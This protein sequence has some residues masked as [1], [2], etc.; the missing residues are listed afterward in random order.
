MERMFATLALGCVLASAG[1]AAAQAPWLGTDRSPRLAAEAFKPQFDN[2]KYVKGGSSALFLSGRIRATDAVSVIAEAP[3]AFGGYRTDSDASAQVGNPYLGVELGPS[4]SPVWVEIGG[5]VPLVGRDPNSGV[6]VGML[7]DIDRFSAFL[8]QTAAL[9]GAVD[10]GVRD[11]SGLGFRARFGPELLVNT[12]SN[13]EGDDTETFLDYG[14][15][16]FWVQGPLDLRL[17]VAGLYNA[18]AEGGDFGERSMHQLG[19]AASY[20][21]AG[22]RPGISLRLPLDHDMTETLDYVL[23]IT[24][25][26]P[27]R[28]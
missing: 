18:T 21:L 5:R 17:H 19:L 13:H 10:F 16:G 12:A 25:E 4:R 28:D 7:S 22:V 23:G 27:L 8:S 2:Q 3:V 6:A 14:A 20:L 1:S 26:V 9:S 11:G 24:L 15:Q